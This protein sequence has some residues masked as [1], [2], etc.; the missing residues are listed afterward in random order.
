M[1][2]CTYMN[3]LHTDSLLQPRSQ[4]GRGGGGV[5]KEERVRERERQRGK[6]RGAAKPEI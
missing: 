6:Q 1:L 4:R 3:V 5:R 2:V